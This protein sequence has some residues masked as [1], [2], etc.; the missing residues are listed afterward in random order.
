[1]SDLSP[2]AI[3]AS[4]MT[5]T[6][7]AL[8]QLDTMENEALYPIVHAAY[9]EVA[10]FERALRVTAVDSV[11]M[12]EEQRGFIAAL[13]EIAALPSSRSDEAVFIANRALQDV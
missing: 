6:R 4:T 10:A 9:D 8:S 13:E 2:E 12:Q 1:M 3:A 11:Q 5:S 7:I